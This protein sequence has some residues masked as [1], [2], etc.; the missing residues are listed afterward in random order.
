MGEEFGELAEAIARGQRKEIIEEAGDC[1]F[2]LIDICGLLGASLSN[3][4]ETKLY[5]KQALKDR[6]EAAHGI[7]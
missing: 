7:E 2:I 5:I 4:I 6:E 1:G 3:A